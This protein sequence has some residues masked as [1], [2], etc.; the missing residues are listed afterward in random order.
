MKKLIAIASVLATASIS[1]AAFLNI[2]ATPAQGGTYLLPGGGDLNPDFNLDW[3]I[4]DLDAFNALTPEEQADF[5]VVNGLFQGN[6]AIGY[7]DVEQGFSLTGSQIDLA[8]IA[9][10]P[11]TGTQLYTLVWNTTLTEQFGLFTAD[12]AS[13]TV[14][15]SN[16]FGIINLANSDFPTS[17]EALIPG[18]GFDG[19]NGLVVPEPST[20]ALIAGVLAL[21]L[22]AYRR[23]RAA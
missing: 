17:G 7:D 15:A 23:R 16:D 8:E 3:G 12:A 21:G 10:Q 22:V 2:L 4:F 6:G 5:T 20:Y 19:S 1:Q 14:P 11:S 18:S 9:G 13:W